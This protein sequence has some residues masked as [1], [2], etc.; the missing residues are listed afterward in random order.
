MKITISYLLDFIRKRTPHADIFVDTTSFY[1]IEE[2]K[3]SKLQHT[4]NSR[5][6][7]FK[8]LAYILK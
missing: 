1:P 5:T 3:E 4:N 2:S 8:K 7:S 6:I